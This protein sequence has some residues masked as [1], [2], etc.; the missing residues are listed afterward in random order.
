MIAINN[1]KY[2]GMIITNQS[3]LG[4]I[5]KKKQANF[6]T[7]EAIRSTFKCSL[8]T[9]ILIASKN[10]PFEKIPN[11]INPTLKDNWIDTETIPNIQFAEKTILK[12]IQNKEKIGIIGDYDVDGICSS[13]LLKEFL[14]EFNIEPIIWIPERKDGYGPSDVSLNFFSEHPVN[15]LI[16]VDCGTNSHEFFNKY[17]KPILIIDHHHSLNP[18]KECVINP[19]SSQQDSTDK[20]KNLCATSLTFFIIAHILKKLSHQKYRQLLESFLDLVALA[21]VC[22]MMPMNNLNR[23]LVKAGLKAIEKQ[24]RIGLRQL[25]NFTNLKLPITTRD[26]GF[27]IG[28][29]LN[30]AGRIESPEISLNLLKSTSCEESNHMIHRLEMTNNYRKEIQKEVF[31]QALESAHNEKSQILCLASENWNPGVVGIVAAMIQEETSKPTII[32]SIQNKEIKASARSNFI[33]IGVLIEKAVELNILEKGGGHKAA[34][35][36]T[37]KVEKWDAFK[38]WINSQ[39][40]HLQQSLIEIDAIATLA[41]IENDYKIL[42]PFGLHNEE[43]K[44]LIKNLIVLRILDKY[45]YIH[46]IAQESFRSFSFFLKHSNEKLVKTIK[47]ILDNKKK[48]DA[49]FALQEKGSYV[50]KDICLSTQSA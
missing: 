3:A 48:F 14:Q 15:L 44:V 27:S 35:G 1:I 42:A 43:P 33:N 49:V 5:W 32:G 37:C 23:A 36:L 8:L 4:N 30:A 2:Q 45:T 13:V 11:F 6:E 18:I 22:D 41:D 7:V 19:N 50:L 31:E 21:T 12:A 10:M 47:N 39:S 28:P 16:L 17:N 38:H 24:N 29:R 26:I 20:L 40:I 9:A 25:I 46:I 34:A